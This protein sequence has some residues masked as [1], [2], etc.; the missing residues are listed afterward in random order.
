MQNS[1][2]MMQDSICDILWENRP[3][4]YL[5]GSVASD[6]FKLGWSDIDILCLTQLPITQA[7]AEQ[8]VNLRQD[9]LSSHPGNPYFRLFEGGMM[10]LAS[11]LSAKPNSVVY[12]GTSGQRITDAYTFD[13]FSRMELLES[14]ILLCGDDIRDRLS[15]PTPAEIKSAVIAHYQAIRKYGTAPGRS[16][17]SIGWMLDIARCLYT[18]DTGKTIAKTTAGEWALSHD[19]VPD[20]DIMRRVLAIRKEPLHYKNDEELMDWAQ[21]LGAP[22]ARF[23]DVL[24]KRLV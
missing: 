17:Y 11:F 20:R 23:A 1:I 6:D 8:L 22:I 21:T 14:G 7:Q 4:L 5:F 2:Q 3:S 24:E 12:W 19:L 9:L 13:V 10:S 18:L 15:Y 16:L